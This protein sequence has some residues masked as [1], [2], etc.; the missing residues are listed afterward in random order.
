MQGLPSSQRLRFARFVRTHPSCGSHCSTVQLLPSSAHVSTVPATHSPA[1]HISPL[2]HA[3]PSSHAPSCTVLTQPTPIS[4]VSF[5]QGSP[6]SQ[7]ATSAGVQR[8][9]A[10]HTVVVTVDETRP[11]SSWKSRVAV[12][13]TVPSQMAGPPQ[14]TMSAHEMSPFTLTIDS[15]LGAPAAVT[16]NASGAA[17][18]TTG[19]SV[20]VGA[21]SGEAVRALNPLSRIHGCEGTCS[22]SSSVTRP[23][24]SSVA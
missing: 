15:V 10:H 20:L 24:S 13:V 9:A 2:V 19:M 3:S 22:A 7:V 4:Q 5:V 12:F 11:R 23:L 21:T 14:S 16:S 1:T 17:P 18:G 6:S 8:C